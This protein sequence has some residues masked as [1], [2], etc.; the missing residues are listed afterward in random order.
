M[1]R[2]T[3]PSCGCSGDEELF[4]ADM[5]WRK[6]LT[7]AL[8]LPSD[9]GPLVGRYVKLFA[10]LKRN[11]SSARACKL[12]HEVSDLVLAEEITFD[13]SCHRIPAHVWA[14]SLQIM[15]DK[16]DLQRPIANHNYLIKVAIGQLT[17]RADFRQQEQAANRRT[18][19]SSRV[20]SSAMQSVG[21][22][23]EESELPE[24]PTDQASEWLQKARK[25]LTENHGIKPGAFMSDFMIETRAKQLYADPVNCEAREHPQGENIK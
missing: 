25:D 11:L 20:R 5:E 15:L 14:V 18:H 24:L 12:L 6:A 21:A 10:P 19:E 22:V 1:T 17:K 4:G 23:L 3:C 13:R 9:C 2:L 16:S 8:A 7:H